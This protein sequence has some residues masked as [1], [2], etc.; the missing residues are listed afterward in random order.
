MISKYGPSP[1]KV[2]GPVDLSFLVVKKS[3]FKKNN[4]LTF[5]LITNGSLMKVERIAD[6]E[7]SAI[8]LT[9]IKQ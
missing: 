1:S 5:I 7:H 3:H 8:L 2:V 4:H 9:S 6:L